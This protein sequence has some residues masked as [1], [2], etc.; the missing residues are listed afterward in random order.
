[1]GRCLKMKEWHIEEND[2]RKINRV[3]DLQ[4]ALNGWSWEWG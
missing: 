1:M 2:A 3:G 4:V